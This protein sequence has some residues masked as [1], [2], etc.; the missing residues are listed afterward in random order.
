VFQSLPDSWAI[1]QLFPIMPVHRLDERPS[2]TGVLA[3]ITCDSDGKID[4]FVSLR[5]TKRALELHELHD[6]EPYYLAFFLVGAYQETLGDLH[7]L[8]G[9]THVVH[10][11]LHDEG[12]WWI[13]ETVKGDSAA[14]VL[15][16]MQYDVERLV[17]Q[18][19]R[20]CERAVREGRISLPEAQRLRRFYE[21]ELVGYTYLESAP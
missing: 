6:G 2:R 21:A 16:Y 18:F 11:K 3:D 14:E 20:D 19:A 9:D 7:N 10:I 4:H 15:R 12:G 5:E 1:D 13:E 17:P 8:F